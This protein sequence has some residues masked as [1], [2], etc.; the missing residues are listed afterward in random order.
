[1]TDSTH[2]IGTLPQL[3]R[4]DALRLGVP[5][6]DAMHEAF[7]E[8]VNAVLTA[9]DESLPQRLD[10]L[11]AHLV[12]HFSEEDA[13]MRTS[14][15]PSAGCHV[16]EHAAVLVSVRAVQAVVATGRV[17]EG[18]RLADALADWF[19]EHTRVMDAALSTWLIRQR[20]GG[21]PV[22]IDRRNG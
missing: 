3:D 16:D 12:S 8:H 10:A 13:Q 18:R 20:L 2:P 14:A 7:I 17:D 22:R 15:F 11:H 9:D 6:M 1:M 4:V 5:A 19:P 21:A